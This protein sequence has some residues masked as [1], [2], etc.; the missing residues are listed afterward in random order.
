MMRLWIACVK[1]GPFLAH[2]CWRASRTVFGSMMTARPRTAIS[3]SLAAVFRFVFVSA[4]FLAVLHQYPV[5]ATSL[6]LNQTPPVANTT[7][8]LACWAVLAVMLFAEGKRLVGFLHVL[9]LCVGAIAAVASSDF[10]LPQTRVS[11]RSFDFF[12]IGCWLGTVCS[13]A[14]WLLSLPQRFCESATDDRWLLLR[15]VG[16]SAIVAIILAVPMGK[17]TCAR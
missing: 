5:L 1:K 17:S 4:C 10:S 3:F 2:G 9:R 11:P 12:L 6:G 7:V 15:S 13:S 16:R 14:F 8:L